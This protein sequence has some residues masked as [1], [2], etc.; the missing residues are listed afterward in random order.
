MQ[1]F[2]AEEILEGLRNRNTEILDFIYDKY[3]YQIKVFI[4]QNNGT[5]EDAKDIYQDAILI[6]YQKI[7]QNNLTLKCS[8]NTYLYSVCR[9]LWLK[10]L[11]KRKLK[12]VFLEESGKFID[13]NEDILSIDERN[14]RYKLYQDHFQ[15]LSYNCQKILELF[16][17]RIQL[18]EIAY[19]L[20]LKSDLYV[21]K[22][23][24]QCKEKLI[25]SIKNDPRFKEI[26]N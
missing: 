12:Q 2:K 16:L 14:E 25:A 9:L 6:I 19:L 22:R 3:F 21:K 18:K 26:T 15:K 8:F 24:H 7:R 11:E 17:A 1:E 20:G 10:Q 4:N 23:K 5:E 13:L